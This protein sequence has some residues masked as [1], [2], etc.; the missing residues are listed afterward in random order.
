MSNAW[1]SFLDSPTYRTDYI[2]TPS[3][4]YPFSNDFSSFP[5][6]TL[7]ALP[8]SRSPSPNFFESMKD[9][10]PAPLRSK[11]R[12][13]IL[14][15]RTTDGERKPKPTPEV[16]TGAEWGYHLPRS[17]DDRSQARSVSPM[18]CRPVLEQRSRSSPQCPKSP[19]PRYLRIPREDTTKEP[20]GEDISPRKRIYEP[21]RQPA[22][23]T[24]EPIHSPRAL[25]SP[26]RLTLQAPGRQPRRYIPSMIDYLTM[27]QLEDVWQM[28]DIYK[29]TVDVPA[30]P[31]TPI[32]QIEDDMDPR[33]PLIELVHPAFRNEPHS[34]HNSFSRPVA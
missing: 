3:K 8:S 29:G 12:S 5:H 26:R 33:S 18:P 31:A 9:L 27:E 4:M 24:R 32:W 22:K 2:L 17:V 6:T 19:P 30:K 13:P 1:S 14:R 7:P 23:Q 34:F 20:V 11:T 21:Y 25:K 15:S 28:Q 16:G 10:M